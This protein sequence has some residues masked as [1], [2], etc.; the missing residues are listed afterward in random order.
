METKSVQGREV[1]YAKTYNDV[2]V[3]GLGPVG[4]TLTADL[5]GKT[6][7]LKM[8]V[9]EQFLF[10]TIKGFDIL[11]PLTNVSHMKLSK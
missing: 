5:T 9:H 10:I 1:T 4:P 8:W 6:K 3:P 2:F 7:D 11:V